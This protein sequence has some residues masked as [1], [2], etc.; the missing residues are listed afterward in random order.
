[1]T[2][3][4]RRFAGVCFSIF[5]V[6]ALSLPTSTA[7]S[8]NSIDDALGSS[9]SLAGQDNGGNEATATDSSKIDGIDDPDRKF[10][11]KISLDE[12]AV[13]F[14]SNANQ[15]DTTVQEDAGGQQARITI[16]E[17][18]A[19]HEYKFDLGLPDYAYID[20]QNGHLFI[21][22]G[23]SYI[24]R[25]SEPWARDSN[26]KEL[27]TWFT[28]DG[29]T[30]TQHVDF[31][32]DTKFPVTADPDWNWGIISGHV[33]FS[34]EETRKAAGGAAG[35]AAIGP[36]WLAVP[37]PFGEAIGAWWMNSSIMITAKATTAVAQD[38]CL[39]LKVGAT[40][41][42][43]KNIGVSPEIYSDGCM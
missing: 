29:D 10:S 30:L 20:N 27:D 11:P 35:L 16:K 25:I 31:D 36:F 9:S 4:T 21:S 23:E 19:P 40:G 32:E 17:N 15:V 6:A 39:A 38:E 22:D 37:P 5:A 13:P 14:S 24:G 7:A 41:W 12:G 8:A 42:N 1:M 34:K 26:G 18:S 43:K 3:E 2:T 28:T 33:Y